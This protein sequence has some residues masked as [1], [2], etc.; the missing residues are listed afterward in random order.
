MKKTIKFLAVIAIV[1]GLLL[2]MSVFAKNNDVSSQ[3]KVKR[4][5]EKVEEKVESDLCAYEVPEKEEIKG[6]FIA[7]RKKGAVK[8][9][10]IF[11]TEVYIRNTGNIPWFSTG[12]KCTGVT[13]NLGTDDKRDRESPFFTD[14]LLWESGWR[15]KNR[16]KMTNLRVDPGQLAYFSFWNRAP[17]EDGYFREIYTPVAEGKTWLDEGKVTSDIN[18]GDGSIPIDNKNILNYIK[19]SANLSNFNLEGD[20]WIHVDVSE[21]KM[22][23]M[24]GDYLV[25]EF[26]VSTGAYRTPTPYGETKIFQK[27]E[28]RVGGKAPHYI[29]PKWMQFRSGGY[30]IHA[31]PSLGNDH[32]VFWREALNHI[33]T[34]R[35]H[36]C[37]RL[38]PKDA[39]FMYDFADI[40]TTVKVVP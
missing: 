25:R 40:G 10:E 36:G 11:Q 21:Q 37:I 34:R 38:L 19:T 27:Q 12:S 35:S 1:S 30:G 9:G 18:V 16:I 13:V 6:Q 8:K 33:G 23:V 26:S 22:K 39:E 17:Q 28:V 3:K 2:P 14:S 20:K 31:L 29:M 4:E 24:V 7:L 5:Q 32:G 15:G